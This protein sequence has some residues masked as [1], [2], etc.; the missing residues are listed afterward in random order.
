MIDKTKTY[1]QDH[2]FDEFVSYSDKNIKNIQKTRAINI[3]NSSIRNQDIQEKLDLKGGNNLYKE[4]FLS[5]D[6][7]TLTEL[8]IM[9]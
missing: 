7:L 2:S 1:D 6:L 8:S 9:V 4:E 5:L 3:I